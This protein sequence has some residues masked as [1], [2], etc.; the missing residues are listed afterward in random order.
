MKFDRKLL[1]EAVKNAS[2]FA[3]EKS[4]N[5]GECSFGIVDNELF[6]CSSDDF[7]SI[8]CRVP[9]QDSGYDDEFFISARD[10]KQLE[11][12]LRTLP[13]NS[14]VTFHTQNDTSKPLVEKHTGGYDTHINLPCISSTPKEEDWWKELSSTKEFLS[15]TTKTYPVSVWHCDPERLMLL[16]RLEPKGQYPLSWQSRQYRGDHVWMLAYG[17]KVNGILIPLDHITVVVDHD[18]V[19]VE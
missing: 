4:W 16:N 3:R 11:R 12:I 15:K 8:E 13:E 14:S 5:G 1:W 9:M 19:F 6:I 17:E 2:L 18:W 10:I 7:I